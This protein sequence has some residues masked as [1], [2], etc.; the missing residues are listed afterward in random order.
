MSN[1]LETQRYG[2]YIY[3]Y[4]NVTKFPRIISIFIIRYS[5]YIYLYPNVTKFARTVA[6][7][8]FEIVHI[9]LRSRQLV[10]PSIIEPQALITEPKELT[11][12]NT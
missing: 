11:D 4:L 1:G 6:T 3:L 7:F 8:I 5:I 9:N 12:I 10:S 2:I